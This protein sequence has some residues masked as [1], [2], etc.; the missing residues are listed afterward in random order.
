VPDLRVVARTSA[1][2]FKG[3]NVNIKT[4]GTELVPTFLGT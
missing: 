4:M 1:F 2:E 3:K